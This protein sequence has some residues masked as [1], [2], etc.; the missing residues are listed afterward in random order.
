[1]KYV[2]QKGPDGIT[3]CSLEPLMLDLKDS[4]VT[5][6]ELE[7]PPEEEEGRSQKLLG[8]KATYEVLGA[9]VQEAN[10]KEIRDA[11]TH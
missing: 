8:L 7:L 6:M 9:L 5:L 3:W 11:T 4:I 1:M 2:L 10:L